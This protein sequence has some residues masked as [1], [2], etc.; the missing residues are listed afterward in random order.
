MT[1][2]QQPSSNNCAS[3]GNASDWALKEYDPETTFAPDVETEIKRLQVLKAY[4][5]LFQDRGTNETPPCYQNLVDLATAI[6]GVPMALINLI[7][8]GR[9]FVVA[10][11]SPLQDDDLSSCHSVEGPRG[12]TICSHCIQSKLPLLVVPDCSTHPI[13]KSISYVAGPPRVRFYASAPLLSP[14]G[15][16]IGTF[17]IMD[18]K[19]RELLSAAQQK[20]LQQLA[21]TF[22]ELANHIQRGSTPVLPRVLSPPHIQRSLTFLIQQLAKLKN[23]TELQTVMSDAQKNIIQSAQDSADFLESILIP[24]RRKRKNEDDDD[25]EP[26]PKDASSYTSASSRNSPT[27]SNHRNIRRKS[28]D[29]NH[30]TQVGTTANVEIQKFVRSIE[31]VMDSFPKKVNMIIVTDPSLPERVYFNDLKV[32]RSV[33]ALLTSACERTTEGYVRLLIFTKASEEEQKD[34]VFECEDTGPDVDLKHY[35]DLFRRPPD[36]QG[37]L[38]P[39]DCIRVDENTGAIETASSRGCHVESSSE[40]LGNGFA[41]HAVAEYIG[42]LGGNYGFRPRTVEPPR[43]GSIFWFSV[44]LRTGLCPV[45]TTSLPVPSAQTSIPQSNPAWHKFENTV[46][47]QQRP[48]NR[49][50]SWLSY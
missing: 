20:S 44:P 50:P 28:G 1:K 47:L 29:A 49:Q 25:D 21:S 11:A 2:T 37:S 8:L 40:P 38:E 10:K 46:L 39:K 48:A 33:I 32:F 12:S 31:F 35:P 23:D 3:L 16:R 5:H 24:T 9:Y 22:M 30:P 7:D 4:Q 6:F 41:V 34:L 36:L 13:F 42:S 43:T 18:Q 45:T 26:Q 19:P 27:Q 14:E 15:Y 17:S